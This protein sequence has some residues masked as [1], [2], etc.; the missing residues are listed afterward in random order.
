MSFT[1]VTA[2]N[3]RTEKQRCNFSIKIRFCEYDKPVG[4]W[5]LYTVHLSASVEI[6]SH[7]VVPAGDKANV[8]I[9]GGGRGSMVIS[10]RNS[11][12]HKLRQLVR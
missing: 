6:A 10:C 4:M 1:E 9:L 5:S 11:S 2:F 7:I 12:F 3:Q 8:V